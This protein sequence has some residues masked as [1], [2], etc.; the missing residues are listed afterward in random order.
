MT[1]RINLIVSRLGFSNH[2][3]D[4]TVANLS[5]GEVNNI[6]LLIKNIII[7]FFRKWN[8]RIIFLDIK[9]IQQNIFIDVIIQQKS[10]NV[11]GKKQK[12]IV[13]KS[14]KIKQRKNYFR[15]FYIKNNILL[16]F[17]KKKKRIIINR[18]FQKF[19]KLYKFNFKLLKLLKI[20]TILTVE[21]NLILKLLIKKKN[22]L[23]M[24][25]YKIFIYKNFSKITYR[26]FLYLFNNY[27]SKG[28]YLDK[29]I[30]NYLIKFTI[31]RKINIYL[32]KK[33]K[34]NLNFLTNEELSTHFSLQDQYTQE[35]YDSPKFHKY[36]KLY[37]KNFF[38]YILIISIGL[39]YQNAKYITDF[40][41]F[42]LQNNRYHM[43]I[44]Y[45]FFDILNACKSCYGDILT[46]KLL[47]IGRFH[48]EAKR[49]KKFIAQTKNSLQSQTIKMPII[50]G[51]SEAYTYTGVFSVKLWLLMDLPIISGVEKRTKIDF[52]TIKK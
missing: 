5:S 39:K 2:W 33:Y 32:K 24:L 35:I 11:L 46:L 27:W 44:C 48:G 49:K 19:I 29:F 17:F 50:F 25:F 22:L 14:I 23:K 7:G 3:L 26:H 38:D 47:V 31:L 10:W 28:E 51:F 41:S 13:K 4:Q 8:I 42:I 45:M 9:V 34:I 15:F 6:N 30:F 52:I 12:Y 20:N 36:Q 16:R 1:R 21:Q 37:K 40:I 43:S 18:I